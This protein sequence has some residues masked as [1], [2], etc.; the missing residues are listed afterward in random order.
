ML[1]YMVSTWPMQWKLAKKY[2]GGNFEFFNSISPKQSLMSGAA[3]I[4]PSTGWAVLSGVAL[5][6]RDILQ[7]FNTI[8]L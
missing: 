5:I 8:Y 7:L 6:C 3:C 2:G 4:G 1:G